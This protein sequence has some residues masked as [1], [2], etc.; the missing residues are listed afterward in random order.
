MSKIKN[1]S[2]D[3]QYGAE[4]IEQQQIRTAGAE[5]V[6]LVTFLVS[7][8]SSVLVRG[9]CDVTSFVKISPVART[10]AVT[11]VLTDARTKNPEK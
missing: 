7:S 11:H 6:K 4:P 3:L 5:A 10:H 9:Y 1:G 8:V 2:L